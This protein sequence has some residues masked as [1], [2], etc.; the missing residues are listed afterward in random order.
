MQARGIITAFSGQ[1]AEGLAFLETAARLEAVVP[2]GFRITLSDTRYLAGDYEGALKAIDMI[3]DQPF[4]ASLCKAASL[5]QLGRPEE[6]KEV[7]VAALS[8]APKGFDAA[9]F[10]RNCASMCAL[11]EDAKR[12]LEGFR[13]A[14]IDV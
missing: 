7:T 11:P 8:I 5:A 4:Y 1:H 6:A 13:K 14:G 3:V 12:W 10:A 9:V 2:P